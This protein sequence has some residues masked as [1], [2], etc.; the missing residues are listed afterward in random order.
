MWQREAVE[1]RAL[2]SRLF[3]SRHADRA[4]GHQWPPPPPPPPLSSPPAPFPPPPP[5]G[6]G[7][8]EASPPPSPASSPAAMLP[9]SNAASPP[10]TVKISSHQC[11]LAVRSSSH[12]RDLINSRLCA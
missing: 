3:T 6:D 7:D 4:M 10:C 2:S 12:V 11:D 8:G 5:P 1:R 9:R